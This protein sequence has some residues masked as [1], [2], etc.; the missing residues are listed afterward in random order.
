MK[1][2]DYL[3]D[4]LLYIIIY[5]ISTF[6][7]I[8]IM[9]LDL[10]IRQE[11]LKMS[12]IIYAFML[13]FILL[14]ILM[15]IDYM[16]KRKFYRILNYGLDKNKELQYI[17]NIPD[18]INKEYDA[19]K[20]L[21]INN[22]ITYKNTLE[23]YTKASKTHTDFNNRWVHQMKTPISVIKLILENE[24]DKSIDENTKRS[25]ES[26][27]EEIE[28]LSHGL[29]MALYTL[30]VKDFE[31]D[32]KVEEV[33]LLEVVRNV[34][35]ENKTS[36]IVNSIYPKIVSKE[37]QIVKSDKKWVKFVISQIISNSIK[38]S[39]VKE[40]K[41][42]DIDILIYKER[43]R[44]ILSIEDKGVG[45]PKQDLDRV[46]NPFF[47][48]RNGRTYLESTGMGL[49]LSKDICER[50]GHGLYIESVEGEGTK[51]TVIF[52]HGNSIYDLEES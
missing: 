19:I 1:F 8:T 40:S 44:T 4:R 23:K 51:V 13:S 21:L 15:T 7:T 43:D 25:Y 32:F 49:Y 27:E 35:N 39:K 11:T 34:I 28:K 17:F 37:D 14:C 42:K 31:L 30:R 47:T 5:F 18:N 33:S 38:Y 36:F 2:K 12:N 50:L 52:Y 26:I 22:Y 24:K 46:F 6:L 45:I 16:K 3:R 41:Y 20:E 10:I 9:M 29:E 48:G